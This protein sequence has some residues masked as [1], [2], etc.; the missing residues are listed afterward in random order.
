MQGVFYIVSLG[1]AAI[2]EVLSPRNQK[3]TIYSG[4]SIG[5]ATHRQI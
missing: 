2:V 1:I 4:V 5:R 3:W